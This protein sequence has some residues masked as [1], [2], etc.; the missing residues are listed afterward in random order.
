MKTYIGIKVAWLTTHVDDHYS[1]FGDDEV[2][3]WMLRRTSPT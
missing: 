3:G 2:K 1:L